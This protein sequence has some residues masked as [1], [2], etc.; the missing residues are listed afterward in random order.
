M[1]AVVTRS[2]DGNDRVMM[3]NSIDDIM[4]DSSRCD[5]LFFDNFSGD[6]I[7]SF[8]P[9]PGGVMEIQPLVQK[10]LDIVME[11]IPMKIG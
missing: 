6:N 10:C 2:Y 8:K 3:L 11:V 9:P 7:N 5:P 4:F 1:S